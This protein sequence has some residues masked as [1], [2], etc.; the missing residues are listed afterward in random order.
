MIKGNTYKINLSKAIEILG[1][2]KIKRNIMVDELCK[3]L[4][5]LEKGNETTIED[6]NKMYKNIA[7]IS[8]HIKGLEDGIADVNEKIKIIIEDSIPIPQISI[9]TCM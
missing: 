7:V 9:D 1:Q 8:L 6:I 2:E 3:T 4:I 5:S